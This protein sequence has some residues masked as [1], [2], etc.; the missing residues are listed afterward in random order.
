MSKIID[1]FVH[2]SFSHILSLRFLFVLA[3]HK[4]VRVASMVFL[5]VL[6]LMLLKTS[7]VLVNKFVNLLVHVITTNNCLLWSLRSFNLSS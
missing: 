1:L 2:S 3:L 7:D 4:R 6:F 5:M